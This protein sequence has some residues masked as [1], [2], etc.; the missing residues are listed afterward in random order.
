MH[1]IHQPLDTFC[2]SILSFGPRGQWR[3][4]E[5]LLVGK[6]VLGGC[7]WPE[8]KNRI[9]KSIEWL[10]YIVHSFWAI[11]RGLF[12]NIFLI[13]FFFLANKT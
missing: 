13:N 12:L 11:K 5:G 6:V 10:M 2:Y 1:Y 3:E 7:P 4:G 8:T 9:A